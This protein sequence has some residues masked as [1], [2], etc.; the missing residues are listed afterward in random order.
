MI[1]EDITYALLSGAGPVTSIVDVRIFPVVVPQGVAMPAIAYELISAPLLGVATAY[2]PTQLTRS[3]VQIDLV[4]PEYPVLRALRTAVVGAM[5][6]QRGVIAGTT[7][8][9]IV[10]DSEGPV[11]FDEQLQLYHRP[12]DFL[13]THEA[14]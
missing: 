2:A 3:R 8:H 13:I 6:W 12:L 14:A 4:G 11:T 10:P 5:R 7:V 1:A 9:S